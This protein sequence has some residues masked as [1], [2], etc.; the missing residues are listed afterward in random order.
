LQGQ[1]KSKDGW[2]RLKIM[3]ETGDGFRIA[4]EDFRIRG[5]GNLLG[6]EQSGVPILRVA[7]PL[8]DMA[9]L[10]SARQE[11]IA[12]VEA[13]PQF[14]DPAYEPLRKRARDLFRET[15]GYIKVG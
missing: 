8:A 5:M 13:D 12:I 3:E 15:G 11:A 1:P 10:E 4:E 2:R 14:N 9:L 6:K 7:D